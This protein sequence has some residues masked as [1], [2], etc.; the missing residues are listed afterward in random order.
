MVREFYSERDPTI[1]FL[2]DASVAMR[3]SV[4]GNS[5]F[6]AVTAELANF[7]LTAQSAAMA[8]G[9]IIFDEVRVLTCIEPRAGAEN[10]ESILREML[11]T[12]TKTSHPCVSANRLN[13]KWCLMGLG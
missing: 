10:R 6:S 11:K 3:T 7:L 12:D 4:L 5:A 8:I 2:V 9:L 13:R 1:V